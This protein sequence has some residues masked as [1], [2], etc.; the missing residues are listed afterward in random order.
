MKK[1]NWIQVLIILY[2]I[3]AKFYN[4]NKVTYFKI[5]KI[6]ILRFVMTYN[7]AFKVCIFGSG[8]VGKSTLMHRYLTGRM[9]VDVK[10]TIGLDIGIK[11]ISKDGKNII[12]Q[13]W[14]LAGEKRF[15][16]FLPGYSLG[17][18]AGIFMYDVTRPTSLSEIEDWLK[19]F[20]PF[21]NEPNRRIPIILIAGKAD[22]EDRRVVSREEGF[23]IAK[24]YNFFNFFECSSKTGQNVEEIF[25]SVTDF[26]LR[27][28]HSQFPLNQHATEQV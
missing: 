7:A 12:L 10:M 28:N 11:Q 2:I 20:K 18:S 13:I 9:N 23:L 6:T 27:E 22:L 24:R 5:A 3:C 21:P 4:I 26:I 15:R 19:V 16:F 8:G 17:A 25:K 1:K 14:D